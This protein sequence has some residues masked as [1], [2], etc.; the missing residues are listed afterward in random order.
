MNGILTFSCSQPSARGPV[1][2]TYTASTTESTAF[3]ATLYNWRVDIYG[4]GSQVVQAT[5]DVSD[6][7]HQEPVSVLFSPSGTTKVWVWDAPNDIST[8]LYSAMTKVLVTGCPLSDTDDTQ[9]FTSS[10]FTVDMRSSV[11]TDSTTKI[12][13]FLGDTVTLQ[14]KKLV[15]GAGYDPTGPVQITHVYDA[16]GDE[17]LSG[18]PV[19]AVT[20]TKAATGSY[21]YALA[22]SSSAADG[23]WSY[24][25][26]DGDSSNTYYFTVREQVAASG[27][28]DDE[29]VVTGY[30][31]DASGAALAERTVT[32]TVNSPYYLA[33]S[34][35][36]PDF[37]SSVYETD[38]DGYI[39]MHLV[40][41]SHVYIAIEGYK[42]SA[43]TI[44][45][46][47]IASIDALI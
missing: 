24:V 12:S 3:S 22:T 47:D 2:I 33:N 8:T 30:L 20:M 32:V 9:A 27:Y 13:C 17:Q 29:C 25:V 28:Q 38:S 5:P 34:L 7:S 4:N 43:V 16:D 42:T 18:S 6:D 14:Y 31:K 21:T 19:E 11:S 40:Q 35:Q 10:G 44:P 1:Y 36:A 45:S 23:Q 37:A 15:D 46:T 39:E 41:A 26:S